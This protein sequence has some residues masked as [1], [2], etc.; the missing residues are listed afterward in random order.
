MRL[1]EKIH[2]TGFLAKYRESSR[3]IGILRIILARSKSDLAIE[4][5]SDPG[6]GV[7][8]RD[9]N[10]TGIIVVHKPL[11]PDESQFKTK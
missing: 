8:S 3:Q 11:G 2:T 5:I 6:L 1:W 9:E 10:L 7:K 4:H